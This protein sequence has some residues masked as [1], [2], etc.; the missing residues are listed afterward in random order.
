MRHFSPALSLICAS[1]SFA[2]TA[3]NSEQPLTIKQGAPDAY[4]VVK[5]IPYGISPRCISIALGCGQGYGR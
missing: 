1:M 2:V 5:G 3:E 4:V